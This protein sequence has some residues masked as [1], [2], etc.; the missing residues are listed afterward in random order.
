MLLLVDILLRITHNKT[1]VKLKV[2][3][4]T[5]SDWRVQGCCGAQNRLKNNLKVNV[6]LDRTPENCMSLE[7]SLSEMHENI[8]FF[9]A[10]NSEFYHLCSFCKAVRAGVDLHLTEGIL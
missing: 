10:H 2:K 9:L 5:Y 7:K 1:N 3:V 8:T 4:K 6:K